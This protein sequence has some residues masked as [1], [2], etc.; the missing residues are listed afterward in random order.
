MRVFTEEQK[1]DMWWMRLLMGLV[2]LG[3]AIPIFTSLSNAEADKT[4]EIIVILIALIITLGAA[5]FVLFVFKLKTKIDEQGIHFGFYPFKTKL[6]CISWHELSKATVRT[7]NP[8][9]EYGGWGYRIAWFGNSGKAYN[10]KGNQGI[11]LELNN[12][13]RILIGTQKPDDATAAIN[14]YTNKKETLY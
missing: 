3:S 5:V 14:Y 12:G 7:Y 6:H 11:Q 2:L 9:G 8:I 4:G 10:V 1:F 13:K